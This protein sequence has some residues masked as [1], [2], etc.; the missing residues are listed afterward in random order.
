MNNKVFR[1]R[2]VVYDGSKMKNF[3]QFT[4]SDSDGLSGNEVVYDGS[5][6]KNFKQ[7][8]TEQP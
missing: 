8:T 5:K 1:V 7:F 4:T 3:K 2:G 6:M